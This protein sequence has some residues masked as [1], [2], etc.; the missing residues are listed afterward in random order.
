VPLSTRLAADGKAGDRPGRRLGQLLRWRAGQ[1]L[2]GGQ[3]RV[4]RARADRTPAARLAVDVP[5]DAGRPP[6]LHLIVQRR[7]VLLGVR[8]VDLRTVD[9][10][11]QHRP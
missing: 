2:R 9:H 8:R 4:R 10:W 11:H 7:A 6:A 5:D 1:H 3:P